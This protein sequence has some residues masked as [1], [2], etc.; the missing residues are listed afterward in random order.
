VKDIRWAV[1]NCHCSAAT[2]GVQVAP[3]IEGQGW[4]R[5]QQLGEPS[6]LGP[7]GVAHVS[8]QRR[9]WLLSNGGE[10]QVNAH[11]PATT[12]SKSIWILQRLMPKSGRSQPIVVQSG[13]G[14]LIRPT[15]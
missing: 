10:D 7:A 8:K 3:C 4:N 11:G 1:A 14:R 15:T 13:L 5:W 9:R 6:C 12:R 2:L